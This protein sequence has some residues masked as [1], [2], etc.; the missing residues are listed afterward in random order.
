MK[1]QRFLK[2]C[3]SRRCFCHDPINLGSDLSPNLLDLGPIRRTI[4]FPKYFHITQFHLAHLSV[5]CADNL[6]IF[7]PTVKEIRCLCRDFRHHI[8][9]RFVVAFVVQMIFRHI[10]LT[11]IIL[12]GQYH[13][14]FGSCNVRFW[15]SRCSD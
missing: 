1:I 8:T 13:R 2:L 6:R 7:L 9:H 14:S 10:Y 4:C 15:S 3:H 5:R 12:K 11:F